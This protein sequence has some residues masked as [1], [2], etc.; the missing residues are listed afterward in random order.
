M[1]TGHGFN[2]WGI[3]DVEIIKVAGTYHLFHLVLPNHAYIAHAV[4]EDGI[5]WKRVKNALFIGEP[6]EWDDSMLWTMHV[7]RDPDK[8]GSFRMFYTGLTTGEWG[9]V[10]R[11]GLAIS[12]DLFD[13]Q[14]INSNKYPLSIDK[15]HY[16]HRLDADRHWV[17]FRDP[18]F[19]QDD[20]RRW[21]LA[22]GRVK[23]GPVVHRG[24]V[25]LAEEVER[26]RFEFKEPL[27]FPG[28]YDDIEV[29]SLVQLNGLYYLIGSIREDLKV[30]YWWANQPEGPYKNYSD[31]V[32]L[33]RGNYAAR[34]CQD[35]GRVLL[36]N[37]F[38]PLNVQKGQSNLL[39]PPKEL[40]VT[41]KGELR[42]K[43]FYKFDEL[44]TRRI[45][46][47]QLRPITPLK[48]RPSATNASDHSVGRLGTESGME[49]FCLNG[50]FEDF[51]LRGLLTLE[52][53]GKCGWAF[54]L[55]EQA[56]GYFVSIDPY[57]GLAQIRAWGHRP[58]GVLEDAYIYETLQASYFVPSGKWPIEFE[59]LSYGKY[60]ELTID[61]Q[62]VLS[63]ADDHYEAGKVG[64]YTEGGHIHLKD[65]YLDVFYP[66]RYEEF[67]PITQAQV[68]E[69]EE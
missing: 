68:H 54:H 8:E 57:K 38:S 48:G 9:R 1:Y 64:F 59:L 24:C 56:S 65:C 10:Q 55:D 40:V 29:P 41:P 14:K 25:V 23:H 15:N 22:A 66:P 44:V 28:R 61:G 5:H 17:S 2:K 42:L 31:N 53:S 37:F 49:I 21:L 18:F 26:D 52:D 67:D 60:M 7:S 20:H 39:P 19:Y 69:M 58:G 45:Q 62:V 16:E 51:R 13:W 11:V 47:Q 3:G 12:T 35:N 63:L 43:S 4:S 30:H 50:H 32:L 6:G 46:W 33:P 27:Y 34:I 36:W